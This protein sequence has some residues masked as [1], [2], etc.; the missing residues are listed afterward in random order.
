VNR[1]I[2]EAGRPL[3][4]V[5]K[6][7]SLRDICRSLDAPIS[8]RTAE[9]IKKALHQNASLYVTA[10]VTYRTNDGAEKWLEFGATRYGLVFTGDTLPDGKK[11]DAVYIILNEPYWEIL[12]SAAVRPLDYDY[13]KALPPAPQRFYEVISRQMFAVIKHNLPHLKFKYSDYCLY[14]AQQR[15]FDYDHFKKQMYKVHLPHIKSGY[16][17]KPIRYEETT[18]EQGRADWVMFYIPGPKARAEYKTF[19]TKRK[20]AP[21]TI[22]IDPSRLHP[23]P[24]A[25]AP[26]KRKN[27]STES[28][29]Q[30]PEPTSEVGERQQPVD[31]ELTAQADGLLKHFY[32][33]FHNITVAKIA[34][35]ALDQAI[36]LIATHGLTQARYIV[37]YAAKEAPK[38]NF[39]IQTFGGVLQYEHKALQEYEHRQ[40][41]AEE[42]ARLK[43]QAEAQQQTEEEE[44]RNDNEL[45]E[46]ALAHLDQLPLEQYQSLYDQCY[47][48]GVEQYPSLATMKQEVIQSQVRRLMIIQIKR[49]LQET[50]TAPSTA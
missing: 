9:Q 50:S 28:A 33:L 20:I 48:Q 40:V 4:K 42:A 35:K 15:Y 41:L 24:N 1:K 43:A 3:P 11:A 36:S 38:T 45:K 47:R 12:N 31:P 23:K 17:S 34:P 44:E 7:G 8:G 10:K 25:K 32:Q 13:L 30:P 21:Q 49:Q 14:S 22:D 16:L 2:D 27:E 26:V 18:D 46:K 29:E 5:I 39:Q 6:L 37:D 19:T